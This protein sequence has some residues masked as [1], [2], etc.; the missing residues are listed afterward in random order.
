MESI[1]IMGHKNPDL[2]TVAS[3]IAYAELKK[4]QGVNAQAFVFGKIDD[5]TRFILEKFNI[6]EPKKI[7][8]LKGKKVILVDH[9]ACC[10]MGEGFEEAEIMEVIDHHNI[11]GD[12]KTSK[13]IK[14]HSEPVGSTCTIIAKYFFYEEIKLS[15]KTA[16][17]LLAGM[18]S[19][20]DLFKSPTT[21]NIDLKIKDRLNKIAKISI[22]KLGIEMFNAKSNIE[23]KT[24]EELL[25]DDSKEFEFPKNI[26]AL[27]SQ[28]K[29]MDLKSFLE[30]RKNSMIKL[31]ESKLK[32]H[33][34]VILIATDL[35][36]EGSELI[37]AGKTELAEK[38]FNIKLKNNSAYIPGLLSRKKQVIPPLMEIK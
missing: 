27:V 2:D 29:L 32:N 26:K 3:A 8:S 21:T 12:I 11:S 38:A 37:A 20:M 36:K 1:I 15:E 19:D 25:N 6:P 17:L 14:Y 7:D 33:D 4:I 23:K 16:K 30:S 24:D 34:L 10:Q 13:P 18:I 35:I 9:C 22:E 28:I 31:M 5:E